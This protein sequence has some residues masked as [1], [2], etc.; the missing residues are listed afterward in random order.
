MPSSRSDVDKDDWVNQVSTARESLTLVRQELERKF[1]YYDEVRRLARGILQSVDAGIVQQDSIRSAVEAKFLDAAGYW[2]PPGLVTLAAWISDDRPLAER[3]IAVA[4]SRDD[5]KT[6]LF[7]SLVCR[8]IQRMEAC[9]AWLLRYFQA[10]SPSAMDREVVVMLDALAN[11][12]F[13]G[14]ALAICSKV[15][16]EWLAELEQQAGFQ[17][18]QRKRWATALDVMT[19]AIGD[20]EYPTLRKYSPTWPK[21]AASLAAARRNQVVQHFFEQMFTGEIVVAP[22]P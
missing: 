16:D 18:E 3:S 8:R 2:L 15:I 1:G 5:S 21:L 17:D 12:V 13:G 9:A 7:F 19:P 6:S 4:L 22:G 14:T 11:G 20:T 10:Q